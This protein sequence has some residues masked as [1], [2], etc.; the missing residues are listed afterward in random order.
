MIA[1]L[2]AGPRPVMSIVKRESASSPAAAASAAPGRG[3][4]AGSTL[5]WLVASSSLPATIWK[6]SR[7]SSSG[8]IFSNSVE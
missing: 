8:R 4:V 5:S 3:P 1:E 6:N 2:E 7:R